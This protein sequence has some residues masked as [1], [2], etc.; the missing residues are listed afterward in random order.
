MREYLALLRD[1]I[2]Q[3]VDRA[4]RTGVGTRA[5]FGRQLRFDLAAG[6]PLVTTKKIHLRSVIYELLWFLLGSTDNNW[7]RERGVG[8]WNE[9]ATEEGG[10]GPIYGR[11]WRSWACPAGEGIVL[12]LVNPI[13]F[14]RNLLE[15]IVFAIKTR[16]PLVGLKQVHILIIDDWHGLLGRVEAQ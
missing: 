8:I 2:D 5:L 3:G 11:Q 4:D 13:V 10:L 16:R 14:E 1:V 12:V 6:F 9:W 7:L 15:A